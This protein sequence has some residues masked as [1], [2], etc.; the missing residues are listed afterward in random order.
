MARL[1][2]QR[3]EDQEGTHLMFR[4]LFD[5][6]NLGT[7]RLSMSTDY[8]LVKLGLEDAALIRGASK[9]R[10]RVLDVRAQRSTK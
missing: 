1:K 6:S 8:Q 7:S 2:I 10:G 5:G 3:E 9:V 4:C